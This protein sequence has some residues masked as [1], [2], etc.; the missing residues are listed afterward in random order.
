MEDLLG[1]WFGFIGI[2][3]GAII[4]FITE[5]ILRRNQMHFDISVKVRETLMVLNDQ[6]TSTQ[7]KVLKSNEL[8]QYKDLKEGLIS[9]K[10]THYELMNAYKTFR[11]HMGDLKAY[12]L[13]S[14]IYQY[15]FDLAKEKNTLSELEYR[16]GYMALRHA[17]GLLIN[18]TRF[19]LVKINSIKKIT[20]SDK[21]YQLK[22]YRRY[23]ETISK[24]INQNEEW[25]TN[26]EVEKDNSKPLY[27]AK[28]T[29]IKRINPFYQELKKID[30]KITIKVRPNY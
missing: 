4:T 19:E 21:T 11:I 16:H 20:K 13:N 2:V 23:A 15:Y 17:C 1:L 22:E 27:K 9:L 5:M 29:L 18:Q 10:D 6:L 3:V 24:W 8:S 14:A 30:P 7:S 28:E 12:E 26:F 25:I